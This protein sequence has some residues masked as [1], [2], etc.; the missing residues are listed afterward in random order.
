MSK[1]E[2][3]ILEQIKST[4]Q[5]TNTLF[6]DRFITYKDLSGVECLIYDREEENT[7]QGCTDLGAIEICALLN[8]L[9]KKANGSNTTQD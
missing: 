2:L 6:K 5:D 8:I 7:L 1:Y 4:K 3:E 9:E